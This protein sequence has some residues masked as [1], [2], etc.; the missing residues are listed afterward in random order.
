MIVENVRFYPDMKIF[1]CTV[2]LPDGLNV[3]CITVTGTLPRLFHPVEKVKEKK[4]Q[5]GREIAYHQRNK[6]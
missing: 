4:Q 3:F 5:T 1:Q 2:I 6:V